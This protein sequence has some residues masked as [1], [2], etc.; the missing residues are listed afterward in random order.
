VLVFNEIKE[1]R[2]FSVGVRSAGK[3]I[4][5]VPTMGAL[6]RGHLALVEEAHGLADRVVLTIFVN[7][8][9]FSPGEDLEA[10]PRDLDDDLEKAGGAGVDAVFTPTAGAMYPNGFQTSVTV[11][12]LEKKLCG[13]SRPG[14]F[15]GVATV[16]LKLFNI[17]VP[18]VAVFGE[19]DYQQLLVIRRM[20]GDLDLD[21]DIRGV[22]TV[23][24]PDGLAMSSR[25]AY[26]NSAGREAASKLPCSLELARSLVNDGEHN[27]LAVIKAMHEVLN[28]EELIEIEYIKAV[29][30]ATLED[31]SLIR[32]GQGA[33]T[34]IQIAVKIGRARLIDHILL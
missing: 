8:T 21:I 22:A 30:A 26:L 12:E 5:L 34:L 6:H 15:A 4:A 27:A 17:T 7:P 9:Q 23:R 33:N 11:G 19:K 1:M 16:V 18:H 31:V 32:G 25:N 24:E 28:A 3:T 14:H 2:A 20:A 10:Y 13:L 29:D